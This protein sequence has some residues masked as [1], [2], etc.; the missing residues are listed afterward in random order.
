MQVLSAAEAISPALNRTRDFLFRPFRWATYVKLCAVAVLTEGLGGNVGH[1]NAGTPSPGTGAPT[2]QFN[3]D[4]GI[5]AGIITGGILLC[6]L[7]IALLYV[8][9]RLRFALFHCLVHRV[10]LLAPGWHSYREQAMRFFMLTIVVGLGF[11]AVAAVALAP[12]VPGFVHVFKESQASGHLNVWEFLPLM[13]QLIPVIL[14]LM[15]AGVAVDVVMRDFMLPHMALEN[16]TAGEAWADVLE[17][18][19][20]QK[21]SFFLY[22]F[23]RVLLPFAAMISLTFVLIIPML[24]VFGVPGVLV[25]MIHSIQVNSTGAAWL[26]AVSL[27]GILGVFMVALGLLVA[28]CFG[29]PVSIAI[30]NYALV[31]YGGRYQLLGD[32]LAPPQTELSASPL[33]A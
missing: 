3:F 25:A 32:L 14:A 24:I 7:G 27:E 30:R 23:L 22:A 10:H 29:G 33:P 21:G 20:M 26:V 11:L 9:V 13:L 18:I 19:G 5:V 6:I 12:F 15:V 16:A 8:V 4:P 17:R 1:S 31:F 28:I 2:A